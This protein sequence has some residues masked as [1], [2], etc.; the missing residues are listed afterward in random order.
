VLR[1]GVLQDRDV[2]IGIFPEIKEVLVGGFRFASHLGME[3]TLAEFDTIEWESVIRR[4]PWRFGSS[5]E[6]S[7]AL[8]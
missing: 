2:G 5:D 4:G 8:E 7:A 3:G 1:L 6:R